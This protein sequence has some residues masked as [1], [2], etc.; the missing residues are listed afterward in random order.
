[1]SAETIS[2]RPSGSRKWVPVVMLWGL[3]L[4]AASIISV[5]G[6]NRL[7]D[8]LPALLMLSI[9]PLGYHYAMAN[10]RLS[11]QGDHLEYRG[12]LRGIVRVPLAQISGMAVRWHLANAVQLVIRRKGMP[13]VWFWIGGLPPEAWGKIVESVQAERAIARIGNSSRS[14]GFSR[15]TKV[16]FFRGAGWLLLLFG[17][18]QGVQ[19]I[20]SGFRW[21]W[22]PSIVVTLVLM[23]ALMAAGASL[24]RSRHA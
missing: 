22:S 1:M 13:S 15:P 16:D 17:G 3:V 8:S 14:N 6:V 18:I 10:M 4:L 2:V 12:P 9:L 21:G 24:Q 11:I 20:V 5:E 19:S 23:I 7:L